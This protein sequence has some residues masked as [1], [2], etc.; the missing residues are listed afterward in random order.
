MLLST[1][2]K[3][4]LNGTLKPIN[5]KV[6][7]LT[8]DRA[9]FARLIEH[10]TRFGFEEPL[11]ALSPG[12][13][14][15]DTSQIAAEYSKYWSALERMKDPARNDTGYGPGNKYF[16]SP[17]ADILYLLVR[18]FAPKRVIEVGCGNSTRITRQAIRD[19][20]LE[21]RVVAIDPEPRADIAGLVD[22]FVRARV[23]SAP[24]ELFAELEPGD[25]LFI[26][27]SHELRAGNDAAHLFCRVIPVIAPGVVIHVHDIFLP[28]EYPKPFFFGYPSWGEQYV[29]H[30]LLAGGGFELIWPGHYLQRTRPELAQTLPFLL[31]GLAQSFWISKL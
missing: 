5:V 14:T 17:D 18:R 29:L 16:E 10:E 23:E 3:T 24:L 30:A 8:A 7:S 12:M 2:V 21:T 15:F 9:E 20:G 19:S 25:I 13:A 11:Y 26:D 1:K 28:Y 4:L 27:S 22:R 31:N 6:E